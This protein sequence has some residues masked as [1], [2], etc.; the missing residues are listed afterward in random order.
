MTVHPYSV[1]VKPVVSEKSTDLREELGLYVFEVRKESTKKDI[2]K[3]VSVT[4]D[5]KVEKVRTL[6]L[7]S[8]IKRRG[9]HFSKPRKVKRA[10]VTLEKGAKL[11]LFEDQ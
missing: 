9:A 7:R 1:I 3:A 10:Y 11:P 5:V 4:W 6:L 2:A 8:K